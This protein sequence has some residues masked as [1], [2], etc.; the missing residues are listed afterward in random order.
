MCPTD[1][2]TP[3]CCAQMEIWVDARMTVEVASH[4]AAKV[5]RE[6]EALDDVTEADVHLELANVNTSHGIEAL[7]MATEEEEDHDHRSRHAHIHSHGNHADEEP[8]GGA[9]SGVSSDVAHGS[10]SHSHDSG[11]GH[12]HDGGHSHSHG[13]DAGTQQHRKRRRWNPLARRYDGKS[14]RGDST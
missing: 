1:K 2:L 14:S 3:S 5:R 11:H 12:S 8:S 7:A 4:I 10:H 9:G 6:V 13:D